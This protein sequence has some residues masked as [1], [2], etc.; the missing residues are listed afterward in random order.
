MLKLCC[1]NKIGDAPKS[2]AKIR[3]SEGSERLQSPRRCQ[4]SLS[5]AR[6]DFQFRF[7]D[8]VCVICRIFGGRAAAPAPLILKMI[9]EFFYFLFKKAG[10]DSGGDCL[11]FE[12]REG[13]WSLKKMIHPSVPDL[14]SRIKFQQKR[15]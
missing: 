4:A 8:G 14:F 9:F 11:Y 12:N 13:L 2:G 7:F 15:I 1:G 3:V 10:D 6:P 5:V